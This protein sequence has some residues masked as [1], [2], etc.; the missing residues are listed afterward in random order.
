MICYSI[1]YTHHEMSR[2][3]VNDSASPPHRAVLIDCIQQVVGMVPSCRMKKRGQSTGAGGPIAKQDKK[4]RDSNDRDLCLEWNA[5]AITSNILDHKGKAKSA[6]DHL[7]N[8]LDK[9]T[10][11]GIVLYSFKRSSES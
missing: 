6:Q 9:T 11:F 10:S 4:R 7:Y 2:T 1:L 8:I 3:Q 5:V